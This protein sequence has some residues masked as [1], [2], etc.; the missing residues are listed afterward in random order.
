MMRESDTARRGYAAFIQPDD[1][2]KRFLAD[3]MAAAPLAPLTV[4]KALYWHATRRYARARYRVQEIVG[5]R[6]G[7]ALPSNLR[8][9]APLVPPVPPPPCAAIV[10]VLG[11][12]SQARLRAT[13][14]SVPEGIETILA[15]PDACALSGHA[16]R[17]AILPEARSLADLV[18]GA[19]RICDREL[20]L[21]LR[22]GNVL[23]PGALDPIAATLAGEGVEAA[24]ADEVL[25]LADLV[26]PLLKPDFDPDLLLQVD[27]AGE[28]LAVR[29]AA[30]LALGGFAAGR[31][32][33]LARDFLLRLAAARGEKAVG[34]VIGPVH[35]RDLRGGEDD[36]GDG[37]AAVEAHLAATGAKATARRAGPGPRIEIARALA[38]PPSVT[39]IVPTRDRLDLLVPC[40]DGLLGGTDYP[41][42]EIIVADNGSTEPE[43]L[44]RLQAYG[45][46]P[47]LRVAP[48]PGPFNFSRINNDA[49]AMARGRVVVF[50]NNDVEVR[51][52]GWLKALVAE[53][54]RPEVGAVGAKLLYPN[55]LIQHAGVVLGL[56]GGPA[57]YAFHLFRDGHPGY[58][59]M[60]ETTRRCSAVT[61]ACLAV[62]RAK[63]EAVG[64][65]DAEA[66]A[67]ALNDVDLCLRL[68]AAGYRSLY[69]PG[70]CLL[71]KESASRPSDWNPDQRA[72]YER[73]L[74]AFIGRWADRLAR[75]PWYNTCHGQVMADFS[76]PRWTDPAWPPAP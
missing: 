18:N 71:H 63:F 50:M 17:A 55:G 3:A 26:L 9:V 39:V 72:R 24:F 7:F 34:H 41:D 64:G 8:P 54:I 12:V 38:D 68:D 25:A 45:R 62:E 20:L 65:F 19:A 6:L 46:D 47:R 13:L 40:L 73:E 1:Y 51:E 58:L 28:F 33:A 67:V 66:F 15:A 14:A 21:V 57:G 4:A 27:V 36:G 30:F 37:L 75:D 52:P 42:L 29:R 76:V 32:G 56:R 69:V 35:G 48:M 59:H 53:A 43:T 74:A 60:L 11:D 31:E 61:A 2:T 70:A 22:P 44:A 5:R 49:V 16:G 23:L 10:P